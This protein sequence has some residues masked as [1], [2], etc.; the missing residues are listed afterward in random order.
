MLVDKDEHQRKTITKWPVWLALK[1][2]G[3]YQ[4]SQFLYQK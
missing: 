4:S 1:I 2:D 3:L